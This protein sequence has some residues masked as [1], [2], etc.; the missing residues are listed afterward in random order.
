MLKNEIEKKSQLRKWKK[1]TQVN[2]V[3]PLNSWSELLNWDNLIKNK[4]KNY[5]VQSL[6]NLIL[7]DKIKI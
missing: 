7:K 3:N 6:I 1:K 5:E 4:L 2:R